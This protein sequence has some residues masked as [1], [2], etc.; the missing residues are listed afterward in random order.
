MK[1]KHF[2]VISDCAV[3]SMGYD[4]VNVVAV[5]HSL[6][7]AKAILQKV[8]ADEKQYAL[9]HGWEIHSDTDSD[10][11]AG[12]EGYYVSEHAHFYIAEV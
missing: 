6:R 3:D 10:F 7:K 1:R 4:E 5:V 2:V 11:D 9:E 12:E 8:A